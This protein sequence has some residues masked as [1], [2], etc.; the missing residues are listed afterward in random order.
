MELNRDNRIVYTRLQSV[1]VK[2]KEKLGPSRIIFS[3]N[4]IEFVTEKIFDTE[5]EFYD[6]FVVLGRNVIAKHTF[7]MDLVDCEETKTYNIW[8]E[9]DFVVIFRMVN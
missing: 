4:G 2:G 5:N 9:D 8:I 6:N 7:E 3:I 1:E